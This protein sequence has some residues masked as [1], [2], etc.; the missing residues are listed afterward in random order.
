MTP[1]LPNFQPPLLSLMFSKS[2]SNAIFE[3]W[4]SEIGKYDKGDIIEMRIIKG[5]DKANPYYYRVVVSSSSILQKAKSVDVSENQRIIMPSRLHTM[6]PINGVNLQ[7]FEDA[8]KFHTQF[9]LCP[10]HVAYK[11]ATPTTEFSLSILKNKSSIKIM[12]A[13]EIS[14]DDFIS[15]TGIL[16]TDNPIIPSGMSDSP[17][18]NAIKR[19]RQ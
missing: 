8:L 10:S 4:I 2:A 1:E 18:Q 13:W 14:G 12:N 5:V 16:P 11:Y 6:T 9:Y 7:R 19:K 15:L 3:E 17:V